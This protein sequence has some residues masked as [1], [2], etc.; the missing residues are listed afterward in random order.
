ML[1]V[2]VIALSVEHAMRLIERPADGA[3]RLIE[4][5]IPRRPQKGVP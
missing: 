1:I 4:R 5:D 2:D 3:H